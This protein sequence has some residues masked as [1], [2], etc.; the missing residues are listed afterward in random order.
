MRC[1]AEVGIAPFGA[2]SLPILRSLLRLGE[3]RDAREDG[4]ESHANGSS[5]LHRFLPAICAIF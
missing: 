1:I 3:D 2:R 5:F 4:G